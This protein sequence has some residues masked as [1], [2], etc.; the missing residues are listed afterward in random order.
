MNENYI[1]ENACNDI[2]WD[3]GLKEQ[4]CEKNCPLQEEKMKLKKDCDELLR[5]IE[6]LA[7]QAKRFNDEDD[8]DIESYL[9]DMDYKSELENRMNVA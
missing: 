2:C 4:C 7:K 9:G 6:E 3:C 8:F 5:K 1:F